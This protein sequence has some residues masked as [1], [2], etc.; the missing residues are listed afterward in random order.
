MMLSRFRTVCAGFL[1]LSAVSLNAWAEEDR[2]TISADLTVASKYIWRGYELS[3]DGFVV[4]PSITVGYKGFSMNLWGNLD[5][6]FD[7]Q[8]PTTSDKSEFTET[9]FTLAY[10]RSFGKFN[11]GVGYI[12]YGLDGI[13]DSEEL[14]F[15]AGLDVLLSPTVTIYREISHLPG[16]Y[17]NFGISHS[18]ELPKGLS[19]DLSGNVGYY[20]S[21]DDAFVEVDSNLNPT[22]DKYR[23][24]HD[25]L[26]SAGLSIPLG[27]YMTLTPTLSY[28][29]PLSGQADDLIK[30]T[31]FSNDSDF[32]Y[33][34]LT[35]SIAF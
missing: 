24:L 12:Y 34:G 18:F 35:L 23:N 11:L 31:S 28:S 16:W 9:D 7:D 5:S 8:D 30:S 20:Y 21:D 22:T 13:D 15:S 2:P 33:G 4:Q 32:I 27:K 29:F 26:L 3:D 6:D 25:G 17:F 10:D 1:I 19:L 14:Y